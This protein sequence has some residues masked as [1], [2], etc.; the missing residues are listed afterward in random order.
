MFQV[1]HF[2]TEFIQQTRA[3]I[4]RKVTMT[5]FMLVVVCTAIGIGLLHAPFWLSPLF[6][7]AGYA[8]GYV[9]QGEILLLRLL[10]LAA[11][12]LRLL[13]G[14]PQIV[15]VQA[16]WDRVRVLAEQQQISGAFAATVVVE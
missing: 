1:T 11:V 5:Q 12:R 9:H 16:E 14:A 3:N 2:R 4:L 7:A 15:N 10:A 8:M 13:L 6:M